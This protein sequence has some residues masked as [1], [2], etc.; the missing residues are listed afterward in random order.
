MTEKYEPKPLVPISTD[1][2]EDI[3]EALLAPFNAVNPEAGSTS[4]TPRKNKFRNLTISKKGKI[5]EVRGEFEDRGVYAIDLSEDLL[6]A[7]T[8]DEHAKQTEEA[9]KTGDF[10]IFSI[11]DYQTLFDALNCLKDKTE[12]ESARR[13]IQKAFREVYP[14][15]L[16]RLKYNP[17]GSQDNV[18]HDYKLQSQS[19]IKEDIVG[20]DGE[21][22]ALKSQKALTAITGEDNVQRIHEVYNWI[23]GTDVYLWRVNSKPNTVDERVAGFVA[24]SGG[25]GLGCDWYTDGRVAGLGV[26]VVRKKI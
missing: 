5:Y 16:T 3:A 22:R 12:A 1:G 17:T 9:R 6:S 18:I 13:F 11:R 4:L 25:A 2:L 14:M 10:G 23:N 7:K 15:T 24:V 20:A 8:Q 26:R 21:I 19:S